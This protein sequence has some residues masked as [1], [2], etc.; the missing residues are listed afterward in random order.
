[1]RCSAQDASFAANKY[2]TLGDINNINNDKV[3]RQSWDAAVRVSSIQPG[4]CNFLVILLNNVHG[5][6]WI[7][8][9][10]FKIL[11]LVIIAF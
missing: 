3:N 1:M 10:E 11:T 2:W 8:L 7:H 5:S 9:C 4:V 6:K